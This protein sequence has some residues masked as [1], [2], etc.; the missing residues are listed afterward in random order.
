M[1]ERERGRSGERQ[2]KPVRVRQLASKLYRRERERGSEAE[3]TTAKK[4]SVDWSRLLLLLLLVLLLLLLLL[5]LLL[6]LLLLLLLSSQQLA[7]KCA[8]PRV[9]NF[10]SR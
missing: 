4:E 10:I 1:G 8:N 3:A 7:T 6:R 5:R 9:V 2:S